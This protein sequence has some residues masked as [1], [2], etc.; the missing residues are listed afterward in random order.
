MIGTRAMT[1]TIWLARTYGRNDTSIAL[2]WTMRI[3]NRLPTTSPMAKPATARDAVSHVAS[4]TVPGLS[5]TFS[6]MACG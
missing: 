4:R 6:R 3:A 5:S 2:D 1:G